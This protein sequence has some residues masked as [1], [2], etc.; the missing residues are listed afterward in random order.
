MPF[1]HPSVAEAPPAAIVQARS[2]LN[3]L[4][5]LFNVVD[6]NAWA[7]LARP[8]AQDVASLVFTIGATLDEGLADLGF[9]AHPSTSTAGG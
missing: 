4:G 7:S 2:A 5:A 3:G 1:T 9:S 8:Q 6:A